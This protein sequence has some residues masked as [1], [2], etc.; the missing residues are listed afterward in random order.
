MFLKLLRRVAGSL[1]LVFSGISLVALL[2]LVDFGS[3]I[4]MIAAF[5]LA[6]VIVVLPGWVGLRWMD[7]WSGAPSTSPVGQS[8]ERSTVPPAVS[9]PPRPPAPVPSRPAPPSVP[10]VDEDELEVDVLQLARKKGGRLTLLEVVTELEVGVDEAEA[11]LEDLQVRGIAGLLVS[12][13]G[14]LVYSFHELQYLADKDSAKPLTATP[15]TTK[16]SITK[17]STGGGTSGS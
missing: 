5:V 8:T 2:N 7:L 11:V 9:T 10:V 4:D 14:L 17:P 1:C 6:L 13:S 3:T 12:D 16:P 15:S